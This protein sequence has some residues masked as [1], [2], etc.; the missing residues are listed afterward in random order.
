M[1]RFLFIVALLSATLGC[2]AQYN[3]SNS[4]MRRV[5]FGYEMHDDGFY[6]KISDVLVDE[7]DHVEAAYAYDKKAQNL[8]VRT[9]T[10]NC[11]VTLNK[12]YANVVKENKHIPQLKNGEIDMRIMAENKT[13]EDK[14]TR[15]NEQRQAHLNDSIAKARAD[16]I[17]R[18]RQDSL[19]KVREAQE[20]AVYA[21]TH[22]WQRMPLGGRSL[23]CMLCQQ[24]LLVGD[25]VTCMA[26]RDSVF[27]YSEEQKGDLG[28]SFPAYHA[29]K[30]GD[31]L[32][33]D[34]RF[35]LHTTAFKDSLEAVEGLST[36]MV[37]TMNSMAYMTYV[38]NLCAAAPN[39]YVAAFE[40]QRSDST[41]VAFKLKYFNTNEKAVKALDVYFQIVD[42]QGLPLKSGHSK[43]DCP[44]E[45]MQQGEMEAELAVQLPDAEGVEV[46]VTRVLV[47]FADG[48]KAGGRVN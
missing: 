21:S 28:L 35:V 37:E 44:I 40:W 23:S 6:Y 22:D 36:D 19:R 38:E 27:Y 20:R 32:L 39:G 3:N 24:N 15:L 30:V 1:R 2:L 8:Y 43:A 12:E 9:A 47:T 7:L 18:V 31:E 14:F 4:F 26:M 33:S 42:A 48:S 13:L 10:C 29:T 46:K 45:Y 25:T 16:S 34:K 11:V 5:I 17:E 41:K